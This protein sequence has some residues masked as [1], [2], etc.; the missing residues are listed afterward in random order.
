MPTQTIIEKLKD[1]QDELETVAAAVKHIDDASK[2]AKTASEMLKKLFEFMNDLKAL[3]EK[4][5]QELIKVHE[6]RIDALEKQLE[7]LLTEFKEKSKQ[8]NQLI[9][10]TKKLEKIIFDYYFEI[11][12]I[13]FPE[14]LDKIDNQIS[15]I[16]IGV[17]N[18]Q[19]AIQN[20]LT[21]V[22]G[23]QSSVNSL[24]HLIDKKFSDLQNYILIQNEILKKET[25]TNRVVQLIGFG[26][27]LII[28]IY[29]MN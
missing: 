6:D 20:T 27:T 29:L 4:H 21:K 18:L 28:L 14:R 25:K 22:D 10:E 19:T 24:S 3:E 2:I 8:L 15:S 16:N 23:V 26:L 9:D 17:G 13:N 12:K 11:K 1:L 7:S 5:R